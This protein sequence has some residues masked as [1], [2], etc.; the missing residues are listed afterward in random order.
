MRKDYT[1]KEE[2]NLQAI[3]KVNSIAGKLA[4]WIMAVVDFLSVGYKLD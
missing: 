1:K 2:F 4:Q 3:Y